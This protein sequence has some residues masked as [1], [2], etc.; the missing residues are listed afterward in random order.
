MVSCKGQEARGSEVDASPGTLSSPNRKYICQNAQEVRSQGQKADWRSLKTLL[1]KASYPRMS[2]QGPRA[3]SGIPV[4]G[5]KPKAK[6]L[7]LGA[8]TYKITIL[9][10]NKSNQVENSAGPVPSPYSPPSLTSVF[11]IPHSPSSPFTITLLHR[12]VTL[13]LLLTHF[14][15]LL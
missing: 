11:S 7:R 9:S 5:G 15:V 2:T 13:P 4:H 12:E 8:F 6:P 10:S 14:L 1:R 3:V